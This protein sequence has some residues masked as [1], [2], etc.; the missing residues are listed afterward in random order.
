MTTRTRFRE[1]L[2][3]RQ[4]F[5]DVRPSVR[6]DLLAGLT[7]AIVALP[8]ALGFGAAAGL[9][10]AAGLVTAI[11]AGLLCAMMGGSRLQVSG[12]TGAITVILIPIVAV[13][14]TSG[15]FM[16]GLMAGA[17]LV[18][19]ALLRL[20]R[21]V[22]FVPAPV[23]EGFTIGIALVIF[24][25][26]VPSALGTDSDAHHVLPGAIDA[27]GRFAGRPA[28]IDLIMAIGVATVMLLGSRWKPAVPFSLLAV[29]AAT[30]VEVLAGV[31]V[32]LI[33]ELPQTLPP[34]S[35]AFFDPGL[36]LTLAPSAMAIA[37]LVS[38]ESLLGA[39][40]AD[41]LAPGA[42]RHHPN[43][44][45]FGQGLA[46]LVVPL[47]GG[48]PASGAVT[49][50]VVNARS[51][52]R[53]RMAA[54]WHALLLAGFMLVAAPLVSQ[55]PLA[56][57]A[58]VLMAT[59]IKMINLRTLQNYVR[60]TRSDG[61]VL[62]LTV[63][64]TVALDLI[65]G[66][67]IGLALAGIIAVVKLAAS[68]R[69]HVEAPRSNDH[70]DERAGRLAEHIQVFHLHG[71]LFFAAG[72]E[73]LMRSCEGTTV[74]IVVL[75]LRNVTTID[76]TGALVLCDFVD[77]LRRRNIEVYMSGVRTD[78][79]DT[80]TV[81]GVLDRVCTGD[82]LHGEAEDAVDA[83]RRQLRETGVL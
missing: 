72:N 27:L 82:H 5:T 13:H 11:I 22:R 40:V 38:L 50:T 52:A 33:G 18:T 37:L 36:I 65:L 56:A 69:L 21:F 75:H 79:H 34:P 23:I 29:A 30:V 53:T 48:M 71:P 16:V 7:V 83:A 6:P 77:E 73:T 80:L 32:A 8:L 1:L 55:V 44:E 15:V 46:N 78:Q 60:A 54:A 49:R 19:M 66:V 25:Q 41:R 24:L 68:L 43:R 76:A 63:I 62:M 35:V 26:Q 51:G 31:D 67:L 39:T 9:D 2:P 12:P 57:L 3:N 14:G 64:A 20:G 61:A 59:T 81:L 42:H 17:V 70:H 28:W 4:D 47:F 10:P 74:S 45:L 58:G